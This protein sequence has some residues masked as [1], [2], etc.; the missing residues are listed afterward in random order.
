MPSPADTTINIIGEIFFFNIGLVPHII[1]AKAIVMIVACIS[2]RNSVVE[3]IQLFVIIK[4]PVA[5][6]I[7]IIHAFRPLNTA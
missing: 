2:N 4:K 7:P 5:K 6:T 1:A 3:E